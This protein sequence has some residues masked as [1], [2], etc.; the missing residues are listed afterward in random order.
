[1]L[2][3]NERKDREQLLEDMMKL[4][5]TKLLCSNHIHSPPEQ[6]SHIARIAILDVLITIDYEPRREST[7]QFEM[8]LIAS[9][10]RTAFSAPDHRLYVRSGY[11]SEPFIAEAAN[12]QLDYFIKAN[13][14]FSMINDLRRKLDEGLIDLG[15]KGEVVM[16]L[17]LRMAYMD[18][19]IREQEDTTS[20]NFSIGCDFVT[21]L[22]ALFADAYHS[23]I[24]KRGSDNVAESPPPRSPRCISKCSRSVHAL[25]QS[26]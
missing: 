17:L 19:I 5:R 1:M 2:D 11:P 9:H 8:E 7:H 24:L 20:P 23:S 13:G 26:C 18:A 14:T 16:R 6:H 3:A 10:M 4:A 22:T 15:Q 21:F 12:R 25:C